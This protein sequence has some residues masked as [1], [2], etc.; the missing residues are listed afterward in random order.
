[1]VYIHDIHTYM[2]PSTHT[3]MHTYILYLSKPLYNSNTKQ[4]QY[5]CNPPPPPTGRGGG[6]VSLLDSPSMHIILK[7]I[8]ITGGYTHRIQTY[9]IPPQPPSPT[10][11]GGRGQRIP[12]GQPLHAHHPQNHHH[13]G[14]VHAKNTNILPPQ[15]HS[16]TQGGGGITYPC[17]TAPPYT[18]S[19]W[20]WPSG[21]VTG[22]YH[23]CPVLAG[24]NSGNLGHH[25]PQGSL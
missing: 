25:T 22:L 4:T 14:G 3:Y 10:H 2:H 6:N 15:P 20:P 12:M 9:Y 21:G 11:R 17:G 1:M 18:W 5:D 7:T 16:H 24:K 23:I 13:Y 8:T 19:S